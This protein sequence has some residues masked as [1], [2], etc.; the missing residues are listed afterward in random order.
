M[1]QKEQEEW[2]KVVNRYDTVCK[3]GK[4]NDIAVLID[5]EETWMQD[6]SDALV[7]QMMQKYNTEKPI[8]FNTLQMY[9]IDRLDFL[10]EGT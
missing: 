6:A 2:Q 7:T 3:K 8:V 5:A 1:T 4:E 10:K 9:R